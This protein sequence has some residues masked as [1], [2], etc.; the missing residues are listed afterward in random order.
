MAKSRMQR[1]EVDG[2]LVV[3]AM[4]REFS[5]RLSK[6]KSVPN[7]S[8]VLV[9]VLNGRALSTERKA[10]VAEIIQLLRFQRGY[11]SQAYARLRSRDDM[12][13]RLYVQSLIVCS[14]ELN[15]LIGKYKVTPQ[16]DP[17]GNTPELYFLSAEANETLPEEQAEIGAVMS[18]LQLAQ[19]DQ[20]D[21]VRDCSCGRFFVAGRIDQNFCS[22][23]C[24]VKAHQSSEEFK[25]KR[26]KADRERYRLHRDGKVRESRGRK[27]GTQKAR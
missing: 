22:V 8:E 17:Y 20:I 27:H 2:L 18:A 7:L 12:T 10:R 25:A 4:V 21:N 19:Y 11:K 15:Q 14:A 24:R 23:K 13:A 26:R 16:I 5:E 1:G 6:G 3:H 9:E